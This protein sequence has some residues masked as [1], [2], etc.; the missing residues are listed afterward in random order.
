MKDWS[1]YS[2]PVQNPW[3]TRDDIP[4]G[5]GQFDRARWLWD[6]DSRTKAELQSLFAEFLSDASEELGT[7]VRRYDP[8]DEVIGYPPEDWVGPSET[9]YSM[10]WE[11]LLACTGRRPG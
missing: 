3:A 1:Y 7:D 8:I 6:A 9:E 10:M 11:Y 5:L 4:E 2:T